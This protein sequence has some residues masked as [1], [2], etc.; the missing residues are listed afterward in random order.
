[1]KY[2]LVQDYGATFSLD[3]EQQTHQLVI[4]TNMSQP[5]YGH[6]DCGLCSVITKTSNLFS[7]KG[8]FLSAN[9]PAASLTRMYEDTFPPEGVEWR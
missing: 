9:E 8:P 5:M 4:A 3:T 2:F 7:K 1:L 6:D